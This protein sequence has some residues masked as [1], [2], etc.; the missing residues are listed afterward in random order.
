MYTVGGTVTGLTGLGLV[1][2]NNAGNNLPISAAGAFTFTASLAS[3]AAYAVTVVTQP[4]SP[5][6]NCVVR[7]GSGT[8][9]TANVTTVAV[10]CTTA[11]SSKLGPSVLGAP[12]NAG[13][14][15]IL[16]ACP[17]VAKWTAAM[18][19]IDL[20][21]ANYK[22]RCPE[23]AV[24]LSVYVSPSIATYSTTND[25][26][27]SAN[28]FWN[29]M[30]A[31]GLSTS[32]QPNQID[33][34]EG[35]NELDNLPNWY[36]DPAAADWVASFWSTLADLMHNAGYIPLVG[37]LVAGQPSPA[38]NFAPVALAMKS[39]AYRWGWCYHSYTFGATTIAGTESAYA[40]YYRQVRDQNGLAG[41]PLVLCEGGYLTPTSTGWQ[42]QLTND[43]YL[44]W[45]KWFDGQMQQDPEVSGLTIFQVGNT[46]DWASFDLTPI[47]Q[48]IANYLTTG[49]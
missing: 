45:L 23:G 34:L 8:V 27:A 20:A 19:G 41:V 49:S 11:S 35:P 16:N 10:V 29:K 7:N 30:L 28:D 33:W 2:E 42:G 5:T 9:G 4:S 32:G 25:A 17:R 43:Q 24:I 6:Q 39:K 40:L 22:S 44:A 47:A 1:L 37:S 13:A 12:N 36:N 3:G 48:E 14:V 21:I 15:T 26:A 46:T 38:T 18:T 31:Q